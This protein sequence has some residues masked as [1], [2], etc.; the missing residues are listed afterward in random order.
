MTATIF[1][2]LVILLLLS[3][4]IATSLGVTIVIPGLI[5][6]DFPTTIVYLIRSVITGVDST[7]LL[8][9][10]LFVLSGAI[11]ARGGIS[12][13]LFNIAALATGNKT[14]GLPGAVVLTCLFYGA[15]SGSGPATCAAVGAM[16]IPEL[17]SLG[18]DKAFSASLVASAAGLGIIIPPSIPFILWGLSTGAS[19]GSLFIAGIIPGIMIALI[20]MVY[21]YFYCR[22]K[23]EDKAKIAENYRQLIS[24][25]VRHV[26]LDGLWA[27]LTPVIILG[28]IYSGVV[29]PTEA[30]GISVFYSLIISLFVYRSMK[31]G[32]IPR[33]LYESVRSYA[34]IIVLIA[35]AGAFSRVLNLVGAPQALES[36]LVGNFKTQFAFMMILNL[37]LLFLGMIIDVGPAVVIIGRLLVPIAIALGVDLVHLG[38]IVTVNLAIGFISPPFGLNLFV[39]SSMTKIPHMEIGIKSLPFVLCYLIALIL[40][41]YIPWFSLALL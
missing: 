30:A 29:T 28:G 25:G 41:T 39:A 10:L 8:A 3:V 9:I 37:V 6:K 15:I 1:I 18:Y 2:A 4:P 38:I 34:P 5:D 11:M 35:L 27:L 7:P 40:V 26:L 16:A 20:F 17:V 31:V 24:K 19:V 21:V 14:G 13:K 23:G 12:K 33:I 32:D 22:R 36:F